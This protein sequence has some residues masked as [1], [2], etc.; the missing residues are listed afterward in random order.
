MFDLQKFATTRCT[1]RTR[2]RRR[3]NFLGTARFVAVSP[4]RCDYFQSAIRVIQFLSVAWQRLS[5]SNNQ[6][7]AMQRA[8][9]LTVGHVDVKVLE[10]SDTGTCQHTGASIFS[11]VVPS[12]RQVGHPSHPSS[13]FGMPMVEPTGHFHGAGGPPLRHSS[14]GQP[15]RRPPTFTPAAHGINTGA[16]MAILSST[17]ERDG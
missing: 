11:L 1:L 6:T 7:A 12:L 8:S 4:S 13:N 2:G 15:V 10:Y 5:G 17:K 3:A 14:L 16:H 9:V